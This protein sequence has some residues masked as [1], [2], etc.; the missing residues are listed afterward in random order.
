MSANYQPH[1]PPTTPLGGKRKRVLGLTDDPPIDTPTDEPQFNWTPEPAEAPKASLSLLDRIRE[2]TGAQESGNNFNVHPNG[3]TGALGQWQVLPGNVPAWTQKH[4]GRSLTPEQF[5]KDPD[6]QIRVFNGEFGS[7]LNKALASGADEDTAIRMAGAGWYGGPG[8]MNQYDNPKRFRPKEPSYREYTMKLLNGVRTRIPKVEAPVTETPEPGADED[9]PELS[10][11]AIRH[12]KTIGRP[13]LLTPTNPTEVADGQ[14]SWTPEVDPTPVP[15]QSE[16]LEAQIASMDDPNSPRAAVL[17]TPGEQP[18]TP[19]NGVRVRV[20]EGLLIINTDKSKKL[21]LGDEEQYVAKNGF[22]GL[23]GKVEDVGSATSDGHAVVARGPDGAEL[24]ASIVTTPQAA[25]AQAQVNQQMHPGSVQTVEPAQQVVQRRRPRSQQHVAAPAS[26][27]PHVQYWLGI[28]PDQFR[29]MSPDQQRSAARVALN[30]HAVDLDRT[31]NKQPLQPHPTA[32]QQAGYRANAGI[33]PSVSAPGRVGATPATPSIAPGAADA[34][35]DIR[36]LLYGDTRAGLSG[37]QSLQLRQLDRAQRDIRARGPSPRPVSST[38]RAGTISSADAQAM[39]LPQRPQPVQPLGRGVEYAPTF[40]DFE[41]QR[42]RIKGQPTLEEQDENGSLSNRVDQFLTSLE[43]GSDSATGVVRRGVASGVQGGVA[44]INNSLANVLSGFGATG[45]ITDNPG[46]AD[47]VRGLAEEGHRDA[48]E[49]TAAD[50][51][52]HPILSSVAQGTGSAVPTLVS[53]SLF[54]SAIASTFG[55]AAATPEAVMSTMSVVEHADKPVRD[56]IVN[57][58][59]SYGGGK[60]FGKVEPLGKMKSVGALGAYGGAESAVRSVLDD[61]M[62]GRTPELNKAG[63]QA[64]PGAIN[65]GA[66][67]LAG[68]KPE[69]EARPGERPAEGAIAPLP[70]RQ[71]PATRESALTDQNLAGRIER[72]QKM[73]RA[74][75]TEARQAELSRL[76]T[77]QQRR[78]SVTEVPPDVVEPTPEVLPEVAPKTEPITDG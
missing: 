20:P 8:R 34:A 38:S 59:F 43:G 21:G 41:N 12:Y 25:Q 63:A 75:Q 14:F 58:L 30:L 28:S 11:A 37:E 73:P 4:L 13:D 5:A 46:V 9:A 2:A 36:A 49:R 51:A 53:Y 17:I 71:E 60:V 68:G 77:E 23:L 57:L 52:K 39:G 31:K 10:A 29:Q 42:R 66:L 45:H 64:S 65:M 6:A 40:R 32:E 67:G 54:K 70:V 26:A 76:V 55:E 44:G 69:T 22:A 47:Y 33:R 72:I 74:Q 18:K 15:E 7:Y 50:V 19:P 24:D 78:Q 62:N 61:A 48:S 27:L 1:T 3:R 16:T 35:G 56:Q